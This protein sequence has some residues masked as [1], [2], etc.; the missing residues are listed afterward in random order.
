MANGDCLSDS[1]R[2]PH[3]DDAARESALFAR[4]QSVE[5]VGYG[6]SQFAALYLR[7]RRTLDPVL[8]QEYRAGERAFVD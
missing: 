6:Y 3:L 4:D 2:A 8:R 5:L 1:Q 7:W